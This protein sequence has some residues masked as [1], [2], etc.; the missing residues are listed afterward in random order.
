MYLIE[1]DISKFKYECF[2]TT[3][4]GIIINKR[5]ITFLDVSCSKY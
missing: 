5:L 4:T 2:I 3:E 1:I